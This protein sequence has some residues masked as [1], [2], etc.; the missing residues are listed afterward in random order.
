MPDYTLR[1]FRPGDEAAL[2][3]IWKAGFGDPDK[4]IDAFFG[5][6]LHPDSVVVAEADGAP[7][8]A[9]YL[10][11]GP[12][13]WPFRK[14]HLTSA[15]A[16]ALATLPQ[17]RGRGIGQAVYQAVCDL[18]FERGF[19]SVCVLPAEESL[20][21][22]YN[23]DGSARVISAVRRAEYT[24]DELKGAPRTMC[25]RIS[26]EEYSNIRE[27]LLASEA[28]GAMPESFYRW[29]DAQI[30]MSGGGWFVLSGGCAAVERD[31]DVCRIREL[32]LPEGD[33]LAAAASLAAYC[34]AERYIVDSPAFWGRTGETKR[35]MLARFRTEPD[36]FLPDDLW[37]GFAFD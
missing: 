7:V 2:R 24:A 4:Y 25:A 17:Y 14:N 8:S 29:Q 37:W 28:H 5:Q 13:L 1:R 18:G 34:R 20:Y 32:I 23:A 19:D 12:T 30:E 33:E 9:M 36:F 22:F 31:G 15:Y 26:V 3:A 21:P 27:S 10:L 16:Y 35:H 6:F 11:D